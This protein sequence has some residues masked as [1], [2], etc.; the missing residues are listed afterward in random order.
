MSNT[1]FV[2]EFYWIL[3]VGNVYLDFS[4]FFLSAT[5]LTCQ[6]PRRQRDPHKVGHVKNTRAASSPRTK[7]TCETVKSALTLRMRTKKSRQT[8][9][10]PFPTNP[11][12]ATTIQCEMFKVRSPI[13]NFLNKR[14]IVH[15]GPVGLDKF[16]FKGS[17][18]NQAGEQVSNIIVKVRCGL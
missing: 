17:E 1:H 12:I 3:H 18:R 4:T 5:T 15:Y 8:T 9:N 6:G 11:L 14:E 13:R 16:D 2:V 10:Y 7:G